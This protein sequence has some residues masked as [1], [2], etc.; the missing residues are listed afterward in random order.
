MRRVLFNPASIPFFRHKCVSK[1]SFPHGS[2]AFRVSNKSSSVTT[3]WTLPLYIF[4]FSPNVV[5]NVTC[6]FRRPPVCSIS[7]ESL[8]R[9]RS[10]YSFV[11]VNSPCENFISHKFTTLSALS[12]SSQQLSCWFLRKTSEQSLLFLSRNNQVSH[13]TSFKLISRKITNNPLYG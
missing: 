2:F 10:S 3:R 4:T 1:R 13:I 8:S 7:V 9:R 6:T 5:T 11:M 12:M